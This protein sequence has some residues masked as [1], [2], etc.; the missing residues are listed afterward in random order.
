MAKE[1]QIQKRLRFFGQMGI[2][3]SSLD[4]T[5][6]EYNDFQLLGLDE[7]LS[8]AEIAQKAAAAATARLNTVQ[9]HRTVDLNTS[10]PL[11]ADIQDAGLRFDNK[12]QEV[13]RHRDEL[14]R[15]RTDRLKE[16]AKPLCDAGICTEAQAKDILRRSAERMGFHPEAALDAAIDEAVK[17]GLWSATPGPPP[18]PPPPP[19][20][21]QTVPGPSSR[22]KTAD[23]FLFES[24]RVARFRIPFWTAL[25]VMGIVLGVI[26]GWAGLAF[27]VLLVFAAGAVALW[28]RGAGGRHPR[29]N[30]LWGGAGGLCASLP[31]AVFSF[32]PHE[33]TLAPAERQVDKHTIA[34]PVPFGVSV[35]PRRAPLW[36]RFLIPAVV[37]VARGGNPGNP[38]DLLRTV[39]GY[40]T[41]TFPLAVSG[42]SNWIEYDF[43]GRKT[44]VGLALAST[45]QPD[46]GLGALRQVEVLLDSKKSETF[47]LEGR[48]WW[49]VIPLETCQSRT[50]R[51]T[52]RSVHEGANRTKASLN[53]VW[54]YAH[55][56]LEPDA[57]W[58]GQWKT[59][60]GDMELGIKGNW[61]TGRYEANR[62]TGQL[63]LLPS[64]TKRLSGFW[65]TGP[66]FAPPQDAG[67]IQF[68]LDDRGNAF[69]G[70]Y[71][72]GFERDLTAPLNEIEA[73]AYQLQGARKSRP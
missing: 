63:T 19:P 21:G 45:P 9:M 61:V 70:N 30:L 56:G 41:T 33:G 46:N 17:I 15:K 23:N 47:E 25:P 55:S 10:G 51:L 11:Q 13:E 53:D 14:N 72:V 18:P 57:G 31:L 49:Q 5:V 12:P 8:D 50:V 20:G 24:L 1:R 34:A 4:P 44:I 37:R 69:S 22:A 35:V 65:R 6:P 66:T 62:K 28:E 7:S 67:R 71:E 60:W 68:T 42:E 32:L 16:I 36:E 27:G 58:T 3:A 54:F 48:E 29:R 2:D 43:G 59:T 38:L 39:D 52:V 64:G 26:N 73:A 40:T